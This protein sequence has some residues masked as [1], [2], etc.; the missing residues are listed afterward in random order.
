MILK[1]HSAHLQ[2]AKLAPVSLL[3]N[4]LGELKTELWKTVESAGLT[5]GPRDPIAGN[6]GTNRA[7]SRPDKRQ[8]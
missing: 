6:K 7:A 2:V 1:K 5:F 8:L 4:Y 3:K